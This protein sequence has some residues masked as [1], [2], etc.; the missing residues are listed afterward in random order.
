MKKH[1]SKRQVPIPNVNRHRPGC[2][3]R[4]HTRCYRVSSWRYRR[5]PPPRGATFPFDILP[6][7]RHIDRLSPRVMTLFTLTESRDSPAELRWRHPTYP[8]GPGEARSGMSALRLVFSC[9]SSS[10][11][12]SDLSSP[13]GLTQQHNNT[14][15]TASP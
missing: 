6:F 14:T 9:S 13:E 10:W 2:L 3:P 12:V 8:R 1:V 5:C 11:G 7:D 15:T 4:A